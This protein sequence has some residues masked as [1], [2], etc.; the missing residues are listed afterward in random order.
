M[1]TLV[2]G[3]LPLLGLAPRPRFARAPTPRATLP[4]TE[5]AELEPWLLE[6]G[7]AS[8][9]ACGEHDGGV[10]SSPRDAATGDVL[11]E[12]PVSACLLSAGDSDRP[13]RRAAVVGGDAAVERAARAQRVLRHE[14]D[15]ASEFAPFCAP[16]PTRRRRCRAVSTRSSW[17][18]RTTAPSRRRPTRRTLGGRAVR[19]RL[20]GGGGGGRRR[21]RR[22]LLLPAGA[23][24]ARALLC[25]VALL[26][27]SAG[28]TLGVRR[29]LVPVLDLANH[30]G[31][32]PSALYAYS[33]A[34]RTGDCIRLHAARPLR[35]ATP[36]PSPTASTP[37][38][39]LPCTMASSRA[40]TRTTTSPSRSPRCSPPRP[41]TPRRTTAGLRRSRRP[42]RADCRRQ[43]C[44][45]AQ[46]R[47]TRQPTCAARRTAARRGGVSREHLGGHRG[48]RARRGR[49]DRVGYRRGGGGARRA[50][51][52][53][54]AGLE[55]AEPSTVEE[56]RRRWPPPRCRP[57][58]GFASR[59]ASRASGCSESC[60]RRCA[61]SPRP[62][63]R[64]RS[65]R[66]GSARRQRTRR[67]TRSR[68]A[69]WRG[70][71]SSGGTRARRCPA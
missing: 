5:L 51:A 41:T 66:F 23:L 19:R 55:A 6:R 49:P 57:P 45:C 59:C 69:S 47:P 58:C 33:G 39:T 12:V 28:P 10:A 46:R 50:L 16:G 31:A 44:S 68:R 67:S 27:L 26:R 8:A 21:R 62:T 60:R 9:V 35:A 7:G 25:V 61:K 65:S 15:A 24:H 13:A 70:G 54:C 36:S 52:G 64:A 11:L 34:G 43:R 63:T 22:L 17:P 42:M 18:R 14:A 2:L 71:R 32:E 56:T 1:A 20:R 53:I 38:P 37:P 4:S 40:S 3:T 29:L 30:D 48:R